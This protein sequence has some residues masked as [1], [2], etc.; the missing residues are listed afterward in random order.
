M[1]S[2]RA[3]TILPV[4]IRPAAA[5]LG[6]SL[7][8]GAVPALAARPTTE[9]QADA[10]ALKA[11]MV[12]AFKRQLPGVLIGNVVCV[13]PLNGV[14]FHCTAYTTAPKSHEN[15][16]FKVAATLH[17]NDAMS[18]TWRLTSHSCSDSV[19]HKPFAC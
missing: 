2:A 13:L 6:A 7:A 16:V 19:T 14:T 11:S 15:I 17:D 5:V 4:R 10:A 18:V 8:L 9:A 1:V 12:T 3:S